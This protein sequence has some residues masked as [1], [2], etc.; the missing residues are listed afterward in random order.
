MEF[1]EIVI[2]STKLRNG[3]EIFCNRGNM[4]KIFP[5]PAYSELMERCPRSLVTWF[6][7]PESGNQQLSSMK[8]GCVATMVVMPLDEGREVSRI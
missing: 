3:S 8:S 4:K 6:V 5:E 7:A 2:V 1:K